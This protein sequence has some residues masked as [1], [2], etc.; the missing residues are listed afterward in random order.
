[1]SG[2]TSYD[3]NMRALGIII[4]AFIA[5]GAVFL[6]IKVRYVNPAVQKRRHKIHQQ[7]LLRENRELDELMERIQRR[8]VR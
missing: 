4:S 5:A 3:D 8:K 2:R 7:E 1:M 6:Y